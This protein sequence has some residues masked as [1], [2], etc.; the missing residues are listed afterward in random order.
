MFLHD[1]RKEVHI[2][3]NIRL[4]RIV[5]TKEKSKN[6]FNIFLVTFSNLANRRAFLY[7]YAIS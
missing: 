7:Y 1:I 6:V 4:I 3:A 2:A 5:I